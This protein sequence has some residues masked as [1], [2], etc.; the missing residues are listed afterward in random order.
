M[1]LNID[2]NKCVIFLAYV[3]QWRSEEHTSELQSPCNFV[4]RLLLEKKYTPTFCPT[5]TP[6]FSA[7]LL[8]VVEYEGTRTPFWLPGISMTIGGYNNARSLL[9]DRRRILYTAL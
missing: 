5:A 2:K 9:S 6:V 7:L 1:F 4:C 8:L 3:T